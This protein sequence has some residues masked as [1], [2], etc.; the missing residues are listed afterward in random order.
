MAVDRSPTANALIFNIDTAAPVDAPPVLFHAMRAPCAC[1][2]ALTNNTYT[3]FPSSVFVHGECSA[4]GPQS[5][6]F[7][8]HMEGKGE[9]LPEAIAR[10]LARLTKDLA[11]THG[12]SVDVVLAEVLNY[13]ASVNTEDERKTA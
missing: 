9:R 11:R 2:R 10:T 5:A 3:F 7:A 4:C 12:E 6:I 13:L 8:P 1:G